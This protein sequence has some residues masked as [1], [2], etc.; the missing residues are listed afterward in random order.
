METC[1]SAIMECRSWDKLFERAPEMFPYLLVTDCSFVFWNR[2]WEG[3]LKNRV[4]LKAYVLL[5]YCPKPSNPLKKQAKK[6]PIK[7]PNQIN[8]IPSLIRLLMRQ[9]TK[10]GEDE[11]HFGWLLGLPLLDFFP[12]PT[13][14]SNTWGEK[15]PRCGL[16]DRMW[17]LLFGAEHG[18]L[19]VSQRINEISSYRHNEKWLDCQETVVLMNLGSLFVGD[20]RKWK[21]ACMALLYSKI[22][23]N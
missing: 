22:D 6:A 15:C 20:T 2:F 14:P 23:F 12:H 5:P 19:W 11:D 18:V 13:I 3:W 1:S 4:D 21:W 7:P 8:N 17:V 9:S 10:E 16:D